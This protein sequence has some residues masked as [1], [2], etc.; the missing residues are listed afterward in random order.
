MN[1]AAAKP[2]V[3]VVISTHNPRMDFLARV[4]EALKQQTLPRE[5]WELLIVDNG[6]TQP[7]AESM[8][9]EA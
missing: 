9:H 3:S 1:S 2:A 4:I 7:L 8:R 5:Q 6:S